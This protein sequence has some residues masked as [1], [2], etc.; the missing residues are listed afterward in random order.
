MQ[1]CISS[2]RRTSSTLP[3]VGEI[4]GKEGD[5]PSARL[6]SCPFAG[7]L[8]GDDV[9]CSTCISPSPSD[10]SSKLDEFVIHGMGL[11]KGV[12]LPG[13]VVAGLNGEFV[14]EEE[15]SIGDVE[16]EVVVEACPRIEVSPAPG[17]R[18]NVSAT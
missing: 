8:C 14:R 1:G 9:P 5:P 7:A 3:P 18:E 6:E 10:E 2:A 13:A 12:L 16:F 4:A 11:S 15:R 17:E